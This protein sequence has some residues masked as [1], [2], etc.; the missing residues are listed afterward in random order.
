MICLC[1]AELGNQISASVQAGLA[2]LNNLGDQITQ[3]VNQGLEPVRAMEIVF[4]MKEGVGGITIATHSPSGKI[5]NT[6]LIN[7]K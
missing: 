3:S 4:A 7:K 2:Q 5:V 1:V 6:F